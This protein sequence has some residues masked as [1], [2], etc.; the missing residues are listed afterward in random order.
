[1]IGEILK[2]GQLPVFT[3][4]KS[5]GSTE[6]KLCVCI[7]ATY[8]A[9]SRHFFIS[10]NINYLAA[11]ALKSRCLAGVAVAS[12]QSCLSM[13]MENNQVAILSLPADVTIT[14]DLCIAY[15]HARQGRLL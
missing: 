9:F 14:K 1:M 11:T 6:R 4:I 15:F 13:A 5:K 12:G 8:A 3:P 2:Q 7:G 10:K